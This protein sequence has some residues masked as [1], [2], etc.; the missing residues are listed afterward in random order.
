VPFTPSHAAAVL[1]FLRTPLPASALLI[2]SMTPDL[3]FYLPVA[4]PWATHTALAVVTTDVLLGLVAWAVW[5]ALLAE[6]ALA[7]APASLRG[8]VPGP[9]PGLGTRLSS[10]GR[11]GWTLLALAVGVATHVLWDEFTHPRRWGPVHVPLLAEQW[12]PLAGY[13]W[14]QYATSVLGG[15][16]L[17]VWFVRWWRRTPPRPGVRRPGV[18]WAWPLLAAVGGTV[19]AVAAFPAPDPG[20]AVFAGATYGGGAALGVALVLAAAWQV[21]HRHG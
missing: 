2:G 17:L 11:I 18:R 1:P 12:G 10:A 19:G 3:P 15:V 20:A 7:A 16:V 4:F 6:P 13:R 14:L 5:H 9:S 21:R 8:R